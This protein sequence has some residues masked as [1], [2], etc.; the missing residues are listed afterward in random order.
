[1]E[2]NKYTQLKQAI[3]V[4]N[5]DIL[6]LAFGCEV[7]IHLRNTKDLFPTRIIDYLPAVNLLYYDAGKELKTC[8]QEEVYIVLGR[9]IRL[10]DV[11]LAQ[12]LPDKRGQTEL[13]NALNCY[14]FLQRWNLHDDNLEHQSEEVKDLLYRL[15]VNG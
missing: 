8:T 6:A 3:Q 15:L 2:R 9:P 12:E 10:A 13:E 5:P 1:M 14:R 11:L 4:A 7:W